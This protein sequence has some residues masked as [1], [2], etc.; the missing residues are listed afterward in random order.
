M[1]GMTLIIIGVGFAIAA[2]AL[3]VVSLIYRNTAGKRVRKELQ[4]EYNK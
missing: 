1:T 2:I 4:D 3:F